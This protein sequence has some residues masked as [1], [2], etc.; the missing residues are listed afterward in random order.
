MENKIKHVGVVETVDGECVRVRIVQSSA[1]AAC[2]AAKQCQASE[3][4]EKTVDVF[5]GNSNIFQKGQQVTVMASYSVGWYAVTLG[6]IIPMF[7]LIAVL[8]S[9]TAAGCG[10]MKAALASLLSLIPYYLILYIFRKQVN[11]KVTFNIE[12]M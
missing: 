1:C 8:V 9:M 7:L 2:K 12:P 10:E 6:M 4:K 3:S 11:R 5:T